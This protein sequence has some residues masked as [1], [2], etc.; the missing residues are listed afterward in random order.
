MVTRRG[1]RGRWGETQACSFLERQGFVVVD[2]NYHTTGGE[3]DIVARKGDDVYFIE[4]KTRVAGPMGNDLAVTPEKVRRMRKAVATYC[5]RRGVVDV[6]IILASL[7]VVV[8]KEAQK[9]A[10]RLAVML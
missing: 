2:R 10:F 1:E 9:V 4:V 3:I 6:G 8:K 5:Y 7:M